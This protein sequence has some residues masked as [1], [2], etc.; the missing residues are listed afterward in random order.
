MV[1]L[2]SPGSQNTSAKVELSK[3]FRRKDTELSLLP[4]EASC[5]H[6]RR[7]SPTAGLQPFNF[8]TLVTF[9]SESSSY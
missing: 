4:L 3:I 6:R 2:V 1:S 7:P 8:Q 9:S 5:L